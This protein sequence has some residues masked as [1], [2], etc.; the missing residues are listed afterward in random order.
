MRPNEQTM[1]GISVCNPVDIDEEYL[2]RSLDYAIRQGF[3]HYQIIGPIHNPVRG[4]VDGMIFLKK[5]SQFNDEKDESYVNENLRVVGEITKK[6]KA[7]GVKTYMWHHEL[8]LPT[9]FGKVYP[10]ILNAY[11][12]VEVSH[13]LV[14][15]FLENKIKDFFAEYPDMEGLVLTLHETKVPLLK[16]KDQKLGKTERVKYVTKILFDTCKELGKELI[17]RPFA[18]VEEDYE[19]MTKAYGEIS[20]DLIVMDKWTQFDWS[21]TLPNNAFFRKIT[22]N[23][24]LIETDIFGEYFGK[25][26]LPLM[27]TKHIKEKVEYCNRFHPLG[28][29]S[30]IDRAGEHPFGDVNEVNLIVME[31]CLTGKDPEQ[32]A[33][34]FYKKRYGDGAGET[35]N[36][37]MKE[38]EEV[39]KKI[40]YLDGYYFNQG[41][42]FPNLNHSKNHFY[43]EI[44]RENYDLASGEW[45]IP[46]GWKRKSVEYLKAEKREARLKAEELLLKIGKA[47]DLFKETDYIAVRDKFRNLVLTAELFETLFSVFVAYIDA[48]EK[49]KNEKALFDALN[50]LV[51]IDARG[52]ELLGETFYGICC[53]QLTSKIHGD[54]AAPPPQRVLDFVDEVKKSYELEK[55][56]RA[57]LLKRNAIDFVVCGGGTEGHS[58]KKEVNFS[59]TLILEH[60]LCRIAGT[61]RG[62]NFS[63]VN[64]HGWFGYTVKIKPYAKNLFRVKAGSLTG[65][66]HLQFTYGDQKAEICGDGVK[67]YLFAYDETEG[68]DTLYIR[69]D[70]ASAHTPC[71]YSIVVEEA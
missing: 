71:V 14:K 58:L 27:L 10:E 45:F 65:Q 59:D 53:K 66:T 51:R 31:A 52:K 44:A 56:E 2:H 57:Q 12:D 11:G 34:A 36:E 48:L 6:A 7:H 63:R 17:V 70:R 37:V 24:L 15:D 42:F 3:T 30:R 54:N 5:Y 19:R 50:D 41:S 38:T 25:G 55:R 29:V 64:A 20:P 28:F 39:Q 61:L 9:D 13:P 32:A 1:N 16:L 33:L 47:K 26:Y 49:G 62:A 40:L 43:F 67:E 68:K 18:S 60:G 69:F 4:N 8:D 21:L 35:L 23:P 46:V 22:Q